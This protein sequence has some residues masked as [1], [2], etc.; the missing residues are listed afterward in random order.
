[1]TIGNFFCTKCKTAF[2]GEYKPQQRP[3]KSCPKC[4]KMVDIKKDNMASQS[5][6]SYSST[7]T[8]LLT[9]TPEV[10]TKYDET[11]MAMADIER[12]KH[13]YK[14]AQCDKTLPMRDRILAADKFVH[15]KDLSGTINMEEASEKELISEFRKQSTNNLVNI[16]K[17]SSL[18]EP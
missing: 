7:N 18:K 1:M 11:L 16:L 10:P 5:K 9:S 2:E 4:H 13:L 3:R 14:M 6:K 12:E 17:E 8:S 15:L